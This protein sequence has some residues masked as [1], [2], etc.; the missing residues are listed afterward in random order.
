MLKVWLV[1]ILAMS[2]LAAQA[3]ELGGLMKQIAAELKTVNTQIADPAQNAA[4]IA[5]IDRLIKAIDLSIAETP[6]KIL[7]ADVTPEVRA[8]MIAD[9]K[10]LLKLLKQQFSEAKA[11]LA[12]GKNAEAKS[13]LD[14]DVKNTRSTGHTRYK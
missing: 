11:F 13:I 8:E 4:S 6:K 9:Y 12:A 2:A 5:A 3:G 7:D 14:V 10:E 1:S